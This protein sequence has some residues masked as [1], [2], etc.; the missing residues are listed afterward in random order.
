[1]C[2]EVNAL[3]GRAPEK[4]ME[5]TGQGS[6]ETAALFPVQQISPRKDP[7]KPRLESGSP[8]K[9]LLFQHV[10]VFFLIFY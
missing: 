8:L 1:M 9:F 10:S 6:A 3:L 5:E 7:K 2:C 4:A